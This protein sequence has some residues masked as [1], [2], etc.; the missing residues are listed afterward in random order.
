[1]NIVK[2]SNVLFPTLMNEFF[3]PDWF[4]GLENFQA[5][6]PPVNIKENETGFELEL[7]IP[8]KKKNDFNLPFTL[9]FY[10]ATFFQIKERSY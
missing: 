5:T 9:C 3:K 2:R 10:L 7:A 1:M 8:G 4:G 6:L